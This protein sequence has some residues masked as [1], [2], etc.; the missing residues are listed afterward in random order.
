M[1]RMLGD[2]DTS[3]DKKLRFKQLTKRQRAVAV[4]RD[5]LEQI[6]IKQFKPMTGTYLRQV[7]NF[8]PS[9][10]MYYSTT[11]DTSDK[12]E[13]CAIGASMVSFSRLFNNIRLRLRQPSRRALSRAFSWRTIALMECAFEGKS[14]FIKEAGYDS[15]TSIRVSEQ[16]IKAAVTFGE[17]SS[18]ER[19]CGIMRNIIDHD[20]EFQPAEACSV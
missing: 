6:R 20:G 4:A 18:K 17:G 8:C 3:A 10:V 7:T 13:G 2:I 19:L 5:V 12:C 9:G 15:G 14:K 16:E 1:I 11:V